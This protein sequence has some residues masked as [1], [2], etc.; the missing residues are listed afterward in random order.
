MIPGVAR[1][2]FERRKIC[3]VRREEIDN[4]IVRFG[5]RHGKGRVF[6]EQVTWFALIFEVDARMPEQELDD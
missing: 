2:W 3:S 6:G 4:N 5:H 1:R